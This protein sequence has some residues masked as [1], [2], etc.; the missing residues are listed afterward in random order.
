MIYPHPQLVRQLQYKTSVQEYMALQEWASSVVKQDN[1]YWAIIP[2][3]RYAQCP[4]CQTSFADWADTYSLENW[5]SSFSLRSAIYTYPMGRSSPLSCDCPHFMGAHVFVNL[6]AQQ[7]VELQRFEIQCGEVPYITPDFF[8][9]DIKTYAV[10]HA[11]PICQPQITANH[12]EP[13]YTVFALTYF[14]EQPQV[15]KDRYRDKQ[16][17]GMDEKSDYWPVSVAFPDVKPSLISNIWGFLFWS[18]EKLAERDAD[19]KLQYDLA[20][21][22]KRGQLGWLDY[23]DPDLPLHIGEGLTLPDIYTNIP[24]RRYEFTWRNPQKQN[25]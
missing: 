24:G 25:K 11:L 14:S 12:F 8:Q 18:K 15:V 19:L 22:A 6:H 20:G 17:E 23:T 3:Y 5:H 7:P 1:P 10:I 4:F 21:W 16:Q 13:R 9:P 2:E